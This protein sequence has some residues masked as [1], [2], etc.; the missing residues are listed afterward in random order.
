MAEL[1][2]VA[3]RVYNVSP[4]PVRLTLADGTEAVY[5][6]QSVEFFGREFRG[7]GTRDDEAG[8]AYRLASGADP[9]TL[10][11]GRRAAGEDGWTLL[12]EVVS[13]E[14]ASA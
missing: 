4:D 9:D 12:G 1:A 6:M 8:T 14:R 3:K 5:R 2:P 10:L 11:L 7:E 13:A